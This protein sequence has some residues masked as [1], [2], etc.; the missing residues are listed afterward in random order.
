MI[1]YL[2]SVGVSEDCIIELALDDDEI[3]KVVSIQGIEDKIGFVDVL[4]GLK[5]QNTKSI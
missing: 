3:Q 5:I 4:L 1:V 2:L